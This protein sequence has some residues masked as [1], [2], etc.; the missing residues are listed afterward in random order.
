VNRAAVGWREEKSAIRRVAAGSWS[1]RVR[2]DTDHKTTEPAYQPGGRPAALSRVTGPVSI[3]PIRRVVAAGRLKSDQAGQADA[4]SVDVPRE[5]QTRLPSR[6]APGFPG[7][8]TGL[9]RPT[10][11]RSGHLLKAPPS[12]AVWS[13][14]GPVRR[15][16]TSWSRRCLFEQIVAHTNGPELRGAVVGACPTKGDFEIEG[17]SRRCAPLQWL[18]TRKW[19]RGAAKL[20]RLFVRAE[21]QLLGK[22]RESS[23]EDAAMPTHGLMVRNA[24][25]LLFNRCLKS[26]PA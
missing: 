12:A 4:E 17:T 18:P 2:N 14:G 6:P 11:V 10:P 1:Y 8:P 16:V 22:H 21:D 23:R 3:G 24:H 20:Q 26:S 19:I 15:G 9:F 13:G 5:W 25:H 7:W